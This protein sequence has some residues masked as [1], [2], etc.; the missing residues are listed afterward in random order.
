VL[1]TFSALLMLAVSMPAQQRPPQ[2]LAPEPQS[3][4]IPR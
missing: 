1:K 4:L 2:I 3:Q